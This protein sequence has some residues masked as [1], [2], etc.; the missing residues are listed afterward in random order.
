MKIDRVISHALADA[1]AYVDAKCAGTSTGLLTREELAER[2]ELR[3]R[4][5]E[6]QRLLDKLWPQKPKQPAA[7]VESRV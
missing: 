1:I 4:R 5:E 3:A 6:Y 2:N 7:E